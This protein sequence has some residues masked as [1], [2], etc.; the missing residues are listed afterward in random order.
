[1]NLGDDM[2]KYD[3]VIIGGGLGSLTTATYLSKRLRN[4][5][6]FEEGK[7]KKLSKY[8]TRLK[9]D[10]NNKYEFKFFAHD[11]GG[12]HEGDLFYEYIKRCGI[13]NHFDYFDNDFAMIIDHNK[14]MVKRPNDYKNFKIH[15]VRRFP[16]QR[17]Q[18]HRLFDD[19][20]R[21]YTDYREQKLA[22]LSNKEFTIPSVLIEWGDLSL[23]EVLDKYFTTEDIINEFSLVYDTAGHDVKDVNAYNYFMK[24]FD[25]FI[26]GSHF[27]QNSYN[28]IVKGFSSE[29]SKTREKIFT[30]RKIKE[31]V[32]KDNEIYKIID[33]DGNEIQAKHYV[34]NMRIDE[35]VDE[36]MPSNTEVKDQFSK[37]YKTLETEKYVNQVYLGLDQP[38]E[39]L[40]I[41][42]KQYMFSEF[43]DD[44]VRLISVVNY[45]QI[46]PSSCKDGRGAIMVEF[47]D[48]DTPRKVKLDQVVDQLAKYFPK[49]VDHV[50]VKKIGVKTPFISGLSSQEYWKD[51][52]V[53]DLFSIDD[54]SAINPF[55]NAYFIGAWLRPEAGITGVIQAGVEYGDIIDDLIYRGDDEDYFITH[56][57]LMSIIYN[58]FIPGALGKEEK[59]V[60]FFVGKDSYYIRTKGKNHRLYKGVTDISDII[61][62]ATNEC[63]YDLSVGNTTLDKAISNGSLEYVGKK[64]FLEEVIDA[65]DMGIE[66]EEVSSFEFVPGQW[67]LQSITAII[68]V[69]LLSNL[70]A[71]YHPYVLVAPLT[72][73]ALGLIGYFKYTKL[74]YISV[75]EYV[76]VG[77]YAVLGILSIFI[78]ELNTFEDSRYTTLFFAVY[79][80]V[81]WLINKPVLYGF[82]KYDY[83]TDYTRTKLFK[84][85]SG[86]LTFIWGFIFLAI[87]IL[88]FS[89]ITSY[90]SLS[91]YSIVLGLYLMYYYPNS[92]IKG[93]IE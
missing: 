67:G 79:L 48:D 64:E 1:L 70:L 34:I 31:F 77:L 18:I 38:S 15:L 6:V 88:S 9:D 19:I 92:Y 87:S 61:I 30:N 93:N 81:T 43:P 23:Y 42:E 56:D 57:E 49:I 3:V 36:Y 14:R 24:F 72:I 5:A 7:T 10:S 62:I 39:K 26:D 20:M 46:D 63:L 28:D 13:E 45:K 44:D 37:M 75:F 84:K 82:I 11:L 52:T 54:Y 51:K 22:R 69:L 25:T 53:N 33:N 85:M 68:G 2:E 74:G 21:H 47:I 55:P 27:I 78:T 91:Y 60:Q 4:V 41:S 17:D 29:I 40:G 66:V 12:V 83:R 65:F 32:F 16:K 59:N 73:L 50:A 90:S 89:V 80:L 71:N 76:S 86:G 58:Q 8:A 35:F